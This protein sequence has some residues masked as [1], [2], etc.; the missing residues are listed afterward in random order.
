MEKLIEQ[1]RF[2]DSVVVKSNE[3][4]QKMSFNLT[5]QQQKIILMLISKVQQGDDDFHEYEFSVAEFCRICGISAG[6][7]KYDDIWEA[8]ENLRTAKITYCGS[9]A[10]PVGGGRITSLQWVLKCSI[11]PLTGRIGIVLDP[12]MRP[13]LLHLKGDFTM[14][15]LCWTLQLS[16]KYSIRL[17]EY[18]KS[19]QY[20][21][22]KPYVFHI[23]LEEFKRCVGAENYDRFSNLLQK[24]ILPAVQEVSEKTD[25]NVSITP[26]KSGRSVDRLKISVQ[27]KTSL[28]LIPMYAEI[29]KKIGAVGNW[30]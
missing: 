29:E 4:I 6:G 13:F 17:Y 21:N 1:E 25:I 14:Y 22:T 18:C 7:K 10:I 23:S 11:N 27:H 19:R 2:M 30:N 20:N 28:E 5:A 8:V 9:T 12:D 15:E 26:E 24:V 3:L 16:R